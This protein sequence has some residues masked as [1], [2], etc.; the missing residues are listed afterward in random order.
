MHQNSLANE[1]RDMRDLDWEI[2]TIL[3]ETQSITK[4]AGL[5][6]MSQPSLSRHLQNIEADLGVNLLVRNKKGSFFTEAGEIVYQKA[7][8]IVHLQNSLKQELERHVSGR[9]STLLIG[10]PRTFTCYR[11]PQILSAFTNL[12]PAVSV[13]LLIQNSDTLIRKIL[14][15]SIDL[16][17]AVGNF[18]EEG[19]E[20]IPIYEDNLYFAYNRPIRQE[21]LAGLQLI[22]FPKNNFLRAQIDSWWNNNFRVPRR[23]KFKVTS[24]ESCL[25]MIQQGL[26]YGFFSDSIY[27]G[28]KDGIY[29]CPL[30]DQNGTE[31]KIRTYLVR[32]ERIQESLPMKQFLEV[33]RRN[34]QLPWTK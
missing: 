26:G 5:F 34:F 27:F 19:L 7:V 8:Q 32:R 2:I 12:Y 16:C 21:E 20:K 25:S 10:A 1:E 15:G 18:E 22:S 11:L 6:Y 30:Y 13:D 28:N 24:G 33:V 17:F 14:E 4:T 9:S 29:T 31:I 3:H 23:V